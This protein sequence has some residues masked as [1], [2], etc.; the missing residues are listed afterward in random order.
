MVMRI[1]HRD[2]HNMFDPMR[3][4]VGN[5][6][7]HTPDLTARLLAA[8]PIPTAWATVTRRAGRST[9][10]QR[11]GRPPAAPLTTAGVSPSRG[12]GAGATRPPMGAPLRWADGGASAGGSPA[13]AGSSSSNIGWGRRPTAPASGQPQAPP[14]VRVAP[15]QPAAASS[16]SGGH[17]TNA[18]QQPDAQALVRAIQRDNNSRFSRLEDAQLEQRETL[19]AQGER[20]AE[21]LELLRAS[22]SSRACPNSTGAAGSEDKM[23]EDGRE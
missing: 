13:A 8:G 15:P 20:I 6:Q 9:R 17:T 10:T 4:D 2:A 11:G 22:Q 19:R 5:I 3:L 12:S 21:I 14:T 18:N 7:Y 1:S 23:D 16:P